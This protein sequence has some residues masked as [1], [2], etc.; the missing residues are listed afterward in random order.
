VLGVLAAVKVAPALFLLWLAWKREFRAALAG[1]GAAA[2]VSVLLP[3]AALGPSTG[4]ALLGDWW[5]L[6]SPTVTEVDAPPGISM[7]AAATTA[8]GQS[9]R[10]ALERTAGSWP[11]LRLREVRIPR[12]AE[13]AAAAQAAPAPGAE[14]RAAAVGPTGRRVLWGLGLFAIGAVLVLGCAR[15]GEGEAGEAPGR[16]ALEASLVLVAVFL[17]ADETARIHLPLLLPAAMAAGHALSDP[18]WRGGASRGAVLAAVA[19]AGLLALG[20]SDVLGRDLADALL[21]K[22]GG[23]AAAILLFGAGAVSLFRER[24]APPPAEGTTAP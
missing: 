6:G 20:C 17:V 13:E 19:L 14:R 8:E 12:T 18:E 4:A 11:Y 2:A 16:L 10:A 22:G 24:V 15:R 21:A 3:G 5:D 23:T 7:D 9:L 1:L